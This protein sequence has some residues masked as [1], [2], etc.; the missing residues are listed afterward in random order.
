V[1]TGLAISVV[2]VA[3]AFIG[4]ALEERA[5]P[6]LR[7][8]RLP[9]LAQFGGAPTVATTPVPEEVLDR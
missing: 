1:P 6:R 3:F 5:D 8:R 7:A 9:T 2:V 4:Y